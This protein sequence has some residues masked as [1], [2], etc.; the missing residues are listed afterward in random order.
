VRPPQC[1]FLL[2][3]FTD[4]NQAATYDNL[5]LSTCSSC[6]IQDDKSAYWTPQLYFAHQNGSVEE[7]PNFGMTI[8]YL[9]LSQRN[10][11]DIYS[12][13]FF[14]LGRGGNSSNTR[15]FP[16]GFRMVSGSSTARSFDSETLTYQSTM[17]VANRFFT[18]SLTYGTFTNKPVE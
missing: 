8:Y 10:G 16:P 15:P 3:N 1:T 9:G 18:L 11:L 17:P 5:Q 2:M 12:D 6:E 13:C 7:V 14:S 4:V